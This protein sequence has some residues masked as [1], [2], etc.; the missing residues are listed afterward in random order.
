MAVLHILEKCGGE[1][2]AE[3]PK[4]KIKRS[5]KLVKNNLEKIAIADGADFLAKKHII[6]G[7][8]K[9]KK[10]KKSIKNKWKSDSKDKH[11]IC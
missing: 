5:D 2:S 1:K 7:W 3:M 11:K 8:K 10:Q 4:I 9:E 6:L